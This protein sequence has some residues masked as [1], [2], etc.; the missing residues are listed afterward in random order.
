VT[1]KD[2]H[3]R[4]NKARAALADAEAEVEHAENTLDARLAEVGWERYR[5][6]FAAKMY[7]RTGSNPCTYD[8]V[9]AHE[10]GGVVA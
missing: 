2:A 3:A 4:L 8:E 7:V 6:A 9:L 5:G 10:L 1:I